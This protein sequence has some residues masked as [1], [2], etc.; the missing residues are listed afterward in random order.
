MLHGKKIIEGLYDMQMILHF[1]LQHFLFL[2]M[3]NICYQFAEAYDVMF[4]SSKSKP[5]FFGRS[6][7]SRSCVH[8]PHVE[9]NGSVIELI[10]HDKHLGNLIGQNCAIHL[11]QDCLSAFDDKVNMVRF[12]FRHI[13]F[14]SLSQI[15]TWRKSIWRLINQPSGTHCNFLSYICD[16]IPPNIQLY[17]CVISFVNY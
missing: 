6:D 16:D 2:N 1:L 12:H 11:I 10:K 5:L 3:L 4:N 14:E 15:V 17:K 13:D 9:F 8:V 7:Y